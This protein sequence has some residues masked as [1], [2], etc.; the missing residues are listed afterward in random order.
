PPSAAPPSAAAAPTFAAT[1]PISASELVPLRVADDL[2]EIVRG[3]WADAA[4]AQRDVAWARA[5]WPVHPDPVLLV[6]LPREEGEA[7][8]AAAD[9]PDVAAGALTG[10]WGAT[11]SK[12]VVDAIHRRRTAGER[13]VD[14]EFSGYRLDPA[15]AGEAEERLR[16]LGGRDLRRLCDILTARAAMLRELS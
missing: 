13:G 12:A 15:F 2:A 9:Q 6:A 5:L 8:A 10:Q 4:V 7:L 3:G 11:L 16:D 1:A 14:V